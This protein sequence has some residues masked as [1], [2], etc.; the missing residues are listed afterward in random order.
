MVMPE[1][2]LRTKPRIPSDSAKLKTN[3]RKPTPC[4]IPR[5]RISRR[6]ITGCDAVAMLSDSPDRRQMRLVPSAVAKRL[7][8]KNPATFSPADAIAL[9]DHCRPGGASAGSPHFSNVDFWQSR[10]II[11]GMSTG[12][13]SRMLSVCQH[14]FG[15][16]RRDEEGNYYQSCVTCGSKFGY[17]WTKMCRTTRLANDDPMK[18]AAA[19]AHRG[20]HKHAWAPRERRLRYHVPVEIRVCDNEEWQHGIS[21]NVESFGVVV[22]LRDAPGSGPTAGT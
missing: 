9:G 10:S 20:E 14:Q 6:K 7:S 18:N 21:E 2:V 5:M 13:L 1:E 11:A 8:A 22:E 17:D 4:T 16:P 3:G 19:T 12:F 15:W